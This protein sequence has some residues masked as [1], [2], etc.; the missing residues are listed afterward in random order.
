MVTM[1]QEGR[2]NGVFKHFIVCP[3]SSRG[4]PLTLRV[5][6]KVATVKKVV[7]DAVLLGA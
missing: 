3:P 5:V 6:I 7:N 4:M 2:F 1:K